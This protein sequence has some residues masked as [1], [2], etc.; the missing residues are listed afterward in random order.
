[1]STESIPLELTMEIPIFN[2]KGSTFIIMKRQVTA[3]ASNVA[4]KIFDFF[5]NL[6][7]NF[8]P[9]ERFHSHE[10]FLDS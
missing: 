8:A 3:L 7:P 9:I 6:L 10:A 2:L 5:E 1:M 4:R